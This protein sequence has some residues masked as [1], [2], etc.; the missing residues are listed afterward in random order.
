MTLN[1]SAAPGWEIL[2]FEQE[3]QEYLLYDSVVCERTDIGGFPIQFYIHLN[4]E[5]ADELYGE[6]PNEEF[7]PGYKSKIIYQPE[8]EIQMLG[9]FGMSGDETLRSVYIPKTIFKRDIESQFLKDYPDETEHEPVPGDT[10]RTLWNNIIYEIV[11]VGSEEKVFQA[12]KLVW[13]FIIKPYRH[14]EES[15]TADDMLF[16]DPDSSEFP[17]INGKFEKQ[18][19]DVFGDN[20]FITKSASGIALDP[21]SSVYGY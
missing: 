16:Y 10:L 14:S 4:P 18:E 3:E 12:K 2:D 21:D 17:E 5:N 9:I 11:D 6:D 7:S 1:P 19:L 20:E 13:E 8:E 15:D